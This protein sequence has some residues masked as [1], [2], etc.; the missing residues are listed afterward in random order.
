MLSHSCAHILPSRCAGIGPSAGTSVAVLLAQLACAHRRA[1][2]DRAASPGPT[3]GPV[4]WRTHRAA[5]R[6]WTATWR[7]LSAKPEF[8]RAFV[9][10]LHVAGEILPQRLARSRASPSRP[11]AARPR[12]GWCAMI[13]LRSSRSRH[14]SLRAR[15]VFAFPVR[16]FHGCVMRVSSSASAGIG[17]RGDRQ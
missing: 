10:Q 9:G 3:A 11:P 17:G 1:A 8:A 14:L 15:A 12:R 2:K 5:C 13:L 4:P 16:A 6:I 7:P